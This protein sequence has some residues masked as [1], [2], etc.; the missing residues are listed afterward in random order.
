[1]SYYFK[2]VVLELKKLPQALKYF[3][4]HK[5]KA[6]YVG[7][8]GMNNLGDE[9]ILFAISESLKNKVTLYEILYR[10]PTAGKYLRNFFSDPDYII[11]GGGTIIRKRQN[12]SYLKILNNLINKY[13]NSKLVVLG[14]GVTNPEFADKIGFPVDKDGWSKTLNQSNF[15][16]VRGRFS[17][18]ELENWN[19]NKSVN[20]FH[21]PAVYF[22]RNKILSKPKTK[23]IGLNFADIGNRVYGGKQ[24]NI[25]TFAYNFV[26]KLLRDDWEV[27]LYP[28]TSK[29]LEYMLYKIGLKEFNQ[30][31]IYDNYSDIF[32]SLDFLE[33]LDVFVGQRLHSIIFS[34]CVFTPF[35]A[36]EYEPKTSDFIISSGFTVDYKTRV[37]ELEVE[38]IYKKVED[39]YLN[40][41]TEQ[42]KMEVNMKKVKKEQVDV[43]S[44]FL[45]TI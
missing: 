27:Y 29:D 45:K 44:Q 34:A 26:Q 1:M 14:P 5:K 17:K 3:F 2:Q 36:L 24:S 22:I 41:N 39:L 7:C 15:I 31:N 28:T 30:L 23:K 32:K 43:L 8:T 12:E 21:D 18:Q 33:S 9:A 35:H 4:S 38:K 40:Q 10:K 6:F 13:P 11:L 37:D 19:V 16:S 42:K 25:D 20:I